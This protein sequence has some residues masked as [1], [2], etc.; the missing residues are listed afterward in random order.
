MPVRTKRLESGDMP[1][2]WPGAPPAASCG[3]PVIPAFSDVIF[4]FV[5]ENGHV[6]ALKQQDASG[7]YTFTQK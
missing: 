3:A 2:P 1:P 7:E 4:E 5:V 6:K